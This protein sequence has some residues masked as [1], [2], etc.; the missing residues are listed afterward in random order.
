M[1]DDTFRL[2]DYVTKPK[3]RRN[4]R[5][6]VDDM[7][8]LLSRKTISPPWWNKF[9]PHPRGF[10]GYVSA[11]IT[12]P[13][14]FALSA[15]GKI[16]RVGISAKKLNFGISPNKHISNDDVHRLQAQRMMHRIYNA[17]TYIGNEALYKHECR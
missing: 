11:P 15:I 16:Q 12:F 3:Y 10:F 4:S 13:S 6:L 14:Y 7:D 2:S 8:T 9:R 5:Y 1:I 17:R